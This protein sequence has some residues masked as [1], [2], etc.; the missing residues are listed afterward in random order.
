MHIVI[1][2][3]ATIAGIVFY[4]SR[5]SRGASDLADAANE[6]GNL[7]RKMRY[8]KK[9]GKKGLALVDNPVEAACIL[10]ISVARMAP[11]GRVSDAQSEAISDELVD[12]MQLDRRYA[13]D[14]IIQMRSLSQYLNQPDST[15]FPMLKILQGNIPAGD[16]KDLSAMM[17]RI[18]GIDSAVSMGQQN[19]IRRYEERMGLLE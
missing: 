18:A 10:M 7:P 11:L 16:A 14:L 12:R 2:I 13:D 3:L 19:F 17:H 8:R 15:L 5:I 6:L 1:G 9:A 4:L